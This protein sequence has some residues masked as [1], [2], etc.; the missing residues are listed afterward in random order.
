MRYNQMTD[1][2]FQHDHVRT[3]WWLAGAFGI[4]CAILFIVAAMSYSHPI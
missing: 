1:E 4:I 3:W 2:E